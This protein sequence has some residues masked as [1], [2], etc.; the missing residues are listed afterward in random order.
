M[1]SMAVLVGLGIC[2]ATA[3]CGGGTATLR[4]MAASSLTGAFDE[5]VAAYEEE[6]GAE[7]D[8]VTAG[9]STLRSQLVDGAPADAVAMADRVTMSQVIDAGVAYAGAEPQLFA[10]NHLALIVPA[11]NPGAIS[12][13]DGLDDRLLAL[14]APQVPCGRLAQEVA[15]AKGTTLI[16]ATEEP[17]VLAVLTKVELGE[18][19]AG[20]VYTSDVIARVTSTVEIIAVPGIEQIKTRYPLVAISDRNES[21]A[22][23]DFVLSDRGLAV[24]AAHGFGPPQ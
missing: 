22:F 17:N 8:L 16:P 14:C 11:G 3:G 9:S 23:V 12:G 6:N 4:V 21:H 10:S 24:L 20:L 18:V 5:L 13:I 2:L 7:V 1:S 15:V 19:D